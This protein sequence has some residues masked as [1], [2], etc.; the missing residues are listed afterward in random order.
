[1]IINFKSK[2][3]ECRKVIENIAA[4]IRKI[5]PNII[6]SYVI[7]SIEIND[8]NNIIYVHAP[9]KIG[10]KC[11]KAI[12]ENIRNG[13]IGLRNLPQYKE[14]KKIAGHG[15]DSLYFDILEG[16]KDPKSD[17]VPVSQVNIPIIVPETIGGLINLASDKSDLFDKEKMKIIYTI[18]DNAIK[19]MEIIRALL[20]S[21]QS[22]LSELMESMTDGVIMFDL[23][24]DIVVLNSIMKKIFNV[25]DAALTFEK[26]HNTTKKQNDRINIYEEVEKALLKNKKIRIKELELFNQFYEASI[27]PVRN[28][29]GLVIGGAIILHDITHL[30]EIDMIKSE[31]VSIV[32]HQLRTPLTAISWAADMI[33]EESANK[34]SK[35]EQDY[36]TKI[37]ISSKR[38]I[39]LVNNLLN[40]A[41]LETGKIN[42]N[43]EPTNIANFI[44]EVVSSNA[45]L[46]ES[47]NCKVEFS[48]PKGRFPQIRID[49]ELM[50]QVFH[51]LVTNSIKYCPEK[52]GKVKITLRKTD[53]N[54]I[55][56]LVS[57]NGIGIPKQ[58][59]NKIFQ[60]FFRADNASRMI[61]EGTG[62][63]LYISKLIIVN[64]GGQINFKSIEG[65]GSTFQIKLP[66]MWAKGSKKN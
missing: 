62:L 14:K 37:N 61:V 27:L 2:H 3:T 4:S 55:E 51:N 45:T 23:S 50:Y 42:I 28:E 36:L 58:D 53:N 66:I 49:K 31:F 60:K 56:I 15:K 46:A 11:L 41:R 25:K 47:K 13:L 21:E 33:L 24:K 34:L 18:V 30:K 19:T 35:D 48:R 39:K 64:S 8:V 6:T 43:P 17:F 10:P 54:H 9:F 52:K 65:K 32:S 59:Q 20:I 40:I 63:G 38:L 12:R 44:E 5:S 26:I 22:R 57:D 7:D 16:G 29:S 1:M